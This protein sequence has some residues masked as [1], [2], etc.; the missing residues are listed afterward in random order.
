LLLGDGFLPSEEQEF[1]AAVAKAKAQLFDIYP[2]SLARGSSGLLAM[3]SL[4]LKSD[5]RGPRAANTSDTKSALDLTVDGGRLSLDPFLLAPLLNSIQIQTGAGA[6]SH[7]FTLVVVLLPAEM[8]GAPLSVDAESTALPDWAATTIDGDVGALVAKYIGK[9]VGLIE[10]WEFAGAQAGAVATH[11][12]D[13]YPN[14][15]VGI[16]D[17]PDGFVGTK[18][19]KWL[20]WVPPAQRA[21]PFRIEHNDGSVTGSADGF[22]LY[23]GGAGFHRGIFRLRKDCIMRRRLGDPSAP[24]R[25]G[26][27]GFCPACTAWLKRWATGE[28]RLANPAFF[29][30]VSWDEGVA[31]IPLTALPV[32]R[33]IAYAEYAPRWSFDLHVTDA[34]G[35]QIQ[36]LRL[37]EQGEASLAEESVAELIEFRDLAVEFSDGSR[38]SFNMQRAFA[39]STFKPSL[40]QATHGRYH[41][42]PVQAGVELAVTDSFDGKCDIKIRFQFC[43]RSPAHDMDP[44]GALVGAKFFPQMTWSWSGGDEGRPVPKRLRGAV[45]LVYNNQL[46]T[47]MHHHGGSM[48]PMPPATTV[49][50]LFVDSNPP[51]W[52][53]VPNAA[54]AFVGRKADTTIGTMPFDASKVALLFPPVVRSAVAPIA[55]VAGSFEDR[56]VPSFPIWSFIFDYH[57]PNLVEEIEIL[58]V[59]GPI[60]RQAVPRLG[61][62]RSDRVTWPAGYSWPIRKL[63]RQGAYDSIHV[64]GL[65]GDDPLVVGTPFAGPM[66]HAPGCAEACIHL[67]WRWGT[68]A[69]LPL[70]GGG[71]PTTDA[72]G[73]K[74]DKGLSLPEAAGLPMIP[75][76]HDLSVAVTSPQTDRQDPWG[77]VVLTSRALDPAKKVVWCTIDITDPAEFDDNV[78][79]PLGASFAFRYTTENLMPNIRDINRLFL[80]TTLK[81]TVFEK[82]TTIADPL[83]RAMALDHDLYSLIRWNCSL[84]TTPATIFGPQIP[85]GDYLTAANV[86]LE[87]L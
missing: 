19:F 42:V 72:Y 7:P 24:V 4:F 85:L 75:S 10:E 13:A 79:L 39:S 50:S 61:E 76:N 27:A 28:P 81:G 12:Q 36:N 51:L 31:E 1:D 44:S 48:P 21:L 83:E 35:L 77:S 69:G 64:H 2:F 80:Q 60:A 82:D 86:P 52:A 70:P 43:V 34:F 5:R 32:S 37:L 47:S 9:F 17:T 56:P 14:V 46:K 25:G 78:M 57:R 16:P 40:R 26:D 59:A 18:R 33:T 71:M 53:A 3:W 41:E 65:M 74:Q 84:K 23:E 20:A 87:D 22:P 11:W 8:S 73:F 67:H 15:T 62:D 63:A 38:E 54:A 6:A 55:G 29:D 58:A 49:A 68:L 30:R 45:R 66:V